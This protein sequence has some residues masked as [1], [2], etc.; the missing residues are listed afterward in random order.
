M[1]IRRSSLLS[2]ER[3]GADVGIVDCAL[4]AT[5]VAKAADGYIL[6]VAALG[7]AT[8]FRTVGPPQGVHRLAL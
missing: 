3:G 6:S 7:T 2:G 5:F 8:V 1:H 4:A